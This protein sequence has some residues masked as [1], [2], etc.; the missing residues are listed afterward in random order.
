MEA[1]FCLLRGQ[2]MMVNWPSVCVNV[3]YW[4]VTFTY[5]IFEYGVVETSTTTEMFIVDALILVALY[6]LLAYFLAFTDVTRSVQIIDSND[7]SRV[8]SSDSYVFLKDVGGAGRWSDFFW[9]LY[10]PLE[11]LLSAKH[12][13]DAKIVVLATFVL[14]FAGNISGHL[15]S[16]GAV[17]MLIT[18]RF[19]AAQYLLFAAVCTQKTTEALNEERKQPRAVEALMGPF[20]VLAWLEDTVIHW[21]TRQFRYLQT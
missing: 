7:L 4:G 8:S 2:K 18:V 11:L 19:V 9:A 14:V 10:A 13:T 3:L 17:Y 6:L 5:F 16:D 15:L 1:F 12:P 20:T 21:Q